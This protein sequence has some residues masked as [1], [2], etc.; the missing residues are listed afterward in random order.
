LP[1]SHDG[2]TDQRNDK[3]GTTEIRYR[4]FQFLS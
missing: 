2:T 1:R 3:Q 4:T